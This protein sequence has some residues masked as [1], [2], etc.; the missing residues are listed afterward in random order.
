MKKFTL[1]SICV[2]IIAMAQTMFGADLLVEEFGVAP[3][4]NSIQAAID[5][6]SDGDR[7]FIKNRTSD[8]P[9]V[10]DV[11]INKNIELLSYDGQDFF[12]VQGDSSNKNVFSCRSYLLN[13]KFLFLSFSMTTKDFFTN[14][15]W[16]T[17]PNH[18]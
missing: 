10:G 4:Y 3:A 9:W 1:Q 7:I 15:C 11:T 17:L 18:V 13:L 8:I 16:S 6:S 2:A 14:H 5:A 12:I